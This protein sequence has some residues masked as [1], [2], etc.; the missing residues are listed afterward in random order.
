MTAK[1][2]ATWLSVVN[3]EEAF[4]QQKNLN[5]YLLTSAEGYGNAVTLTSSSSSEYD[6]EGV[7]DVPDSVC[8]KIE[9][10]GD[11]AQDFDF[12]NMANAKD[13]LWSIGNGEDV[14]IGKD[15]LIKCKG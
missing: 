12:F 13:T 2:S 15:P 9:G 4:A 6:V 14:L 5:T 11:E 3:Q 1:E 7:D 8:P 10:Q